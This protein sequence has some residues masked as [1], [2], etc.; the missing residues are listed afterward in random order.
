MAQLLVRKADERKR[1]KSHGSDSGAGSSA[2]SSA[3]CHAQLPGAAICVDRD[4]HDRRIQR[5]L[6][7]VGFLFAAIGRLWPSA[8]RLGLGHLPGELIIHTP[9]LKLFVLFTTMLV[10]S[11]SLSIV[12]WLLQR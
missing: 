11:V 7:T 8:S 6:I 2:H 5:A 4:V 12:L 9:G 1:I 10:V 3:P